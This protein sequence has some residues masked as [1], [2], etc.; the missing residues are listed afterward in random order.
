[1]IRMLATLGLL[2]CSARVAWAEV[3][4]IRITR[5]PSIIYLAPIIME[6]QKLVERAATAMGVPGLTAKYIVFGSGG[7]ATDTLL[8]GNVDVV[9]TGASNMLL[10]WDR[11]KGQVKGL[12]GAAVLP[13]WALSRNPA[14]KTLRDLTASDR[15]AVPTVKVSTQAI[16]L[17]IAARQLFG[18]AEFGRFD[19][20]Q[21]TMAHPDGA[22]ALM[23]G[24]GGVSA[25]FSASPYQEEEAGTPGLHIIAR[26]DEILGQKFSNPVYFTTAKFRDANPTV[27]RAFVAA[28]RE[29]AA[30]IAAH[31]REASEIYLKA[32]G[33]KYT[34]DTL[35]RII[36]DGTQTF[37]ATPYGMKRIA[38]HM[39]DTKVLRG[40]ADSWRDFFFPEAHGMEGN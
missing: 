11:T 2:L 14:V 17:Q 1:M 28:A 13:M 15:I 3:T 5:Q 21:V 7:S 23:T 18:D 36:G 8:S 4:E 6:Q 25:H 9:T 22:A 16:L 32:T 37:D 34:V 33:E 12:A 20:L 10:L 26:S 24:G 35:V 29:A 31:P 30:F 39:A 27:V 19:P 40:R 38:D